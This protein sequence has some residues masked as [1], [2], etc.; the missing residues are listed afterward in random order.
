MEEAPRGQQGGC[1]ATKEVGLGGTRD[2]TVD[3][4]LKIQGPRL[5]RGHQGSSHIKGWGSD[6]LGRATFSVLICFDPPI[7]SALLDIFS[8]LPQRTVASPAEMQVASSIQEASRSQPQFLPHQPQDPTRDK[9][10]WIWVSRG[11][12][13]VP[14]PEGEHTACMGQPSASGSPDDRRWNCLLNWGFLGAT[15]ANI[16]KRPE[17]Q[18]RGTRMDHSLLCSKIDAF[19]PTRCF[20]Q[21]T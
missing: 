10:L 9:T 11:S 21:L 4:R 7:S 20:G 19:P 6:S 13:E 2:W 8:C 17:A 5:F 12:G 14:Q 1:T 3:T 16:L 18:R 15:S